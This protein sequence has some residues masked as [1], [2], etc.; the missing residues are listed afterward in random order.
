MTG[1]TLLE[2][3]AFMVVIAPGDRH[4]PLVPAPGPTGPAPLTA[5]Q[6]EAAAGEQPE[7]V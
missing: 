5:R 2:L 4:G 7:S 3:S 6:Q 1:A